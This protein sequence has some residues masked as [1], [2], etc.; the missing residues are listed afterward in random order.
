MVISTGWPAMALTAWSP[1]NPAPMTTTRG[2]GAVTSSG[3][4]VGT[5]AQWHVEVDVAHLAAQLVVSARA[6]VT[7]SATWGKMA[8]SRA[9][10]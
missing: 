10:A 4:R 9:G 8:S 3:V 1:A 5:A 2:S 7:M 6:A